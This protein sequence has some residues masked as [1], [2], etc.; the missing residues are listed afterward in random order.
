MPA[1]SRLP[2]GLC[3]R[4]S[5]ILLTAAACSLGD[6]HGTGP[7]P[8][9]ENSPSQARIVAGVYLSLGPRPCSDSPSAP[10]TWGGAR[11]TLRPDNTYL[12]VAAFWALGA[13]PLA[14]DSASANYVDHGTWEAQQ[15]ASSIGFLRSTER[16][17]TRAM[18]YG[19]ADSTLLTMLADE[20]VAGCSS[21]V[22]LRLVP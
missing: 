21:I 15:G 17:V 6:A 5:A 7:A 2:R 14:V 22:T 10:A 3:A 12:F 11:L 13:A 1:L 20:P 4:W 18:L 19:P 8:P 9:T 16:S